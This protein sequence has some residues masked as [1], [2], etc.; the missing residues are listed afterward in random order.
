MGSGILPKNI[1]CIMVGVGEGRL[2]KGCLRKRLPFGIVQFLG[3][4]G[5]SKASLTTFLSYLLFSD[6]R[7]QCLILYFLTYFPKVH[8]ENQNPS[9]HKTY[10][11][12]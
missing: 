12:C 10:A 7:K 5:R 11:E 8:N 6:I 2:P 3:W 9:V 4:I 1:L